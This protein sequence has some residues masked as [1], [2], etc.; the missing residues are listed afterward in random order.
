MELQSSLKTAVDSL[1]NR[2]QDLHG[3][4][5]EEREQRRNDIEHLATSLVGKV[6]ECVTALDEERSVRVTEQTVSI[7][8]FGEDLITLQQRIEAEKLNRDSEL[9]AL[10]SEIH[11]VLGNRSA[12]DEHFKAATLEELA[13]LKSSLAL[14][15]EERVAEDDEIVQ[16]INDYTRAL[17]E[18]LKLVNT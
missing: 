13:A 10:R 14:E 3:L 7:K 5:R 18:G 8:R 11:D 12:N 1:T 15:R 6:N 4:V 17:Q 2:I 16:A 9:G